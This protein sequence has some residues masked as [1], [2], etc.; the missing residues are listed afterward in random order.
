ETE[1]AAAALLWFGHG[2]WH[3]TR[4]GRISKGA[5]IVASPAIRVAARR[6]A[7]GMAVPHTDGLEGEST[8]DE[9]RRAAARA[10]AASQFPGNIGAPTVGRA[11][12]RETAGAVAAHA[13]RGE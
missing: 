4:A 11:G 2:H 6:C 9:A 5:V 8:G 3:R 12:G 7:A 10:R 1:N 13:Q